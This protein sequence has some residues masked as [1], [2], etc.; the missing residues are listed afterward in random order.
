MIGSCARQLLVY[1]LSIV[2][3]ID[4]VSN[5]MVRNRPSSFFSYLLCLRVSIMELDDIEQILERRILM[6]Q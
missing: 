2:I 3:V 5:M 1:S 4:V 6:R